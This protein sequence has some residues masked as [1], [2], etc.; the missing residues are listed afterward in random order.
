[1]ID[2]HKL[3]VTIENIFSDN[4]EIA[5]PFSHIGLKFDDAFKIGIEKNYIE[6]KNKYWFNTQK[7]INIFTL[8]DIKKDKTF[9][10]TKDDFIYILDKYKRDTDTYNNFYDRIKRNN[11]I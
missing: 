5:G 6:I 7:R 1:M 9:D 11:I 2:R 8:Y 4:F 10:L 3:P